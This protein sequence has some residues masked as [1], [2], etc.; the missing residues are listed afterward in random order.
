MRIEQADVAQLTDDQL[1]HLAVE[2][3]KLACRGGPLLTFAGELS[4]L[5]DC[6]IDKERMPSATVK[7]VRFFLHVIIIPGFIF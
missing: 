6:I 3:H 4:L 7:M 1:K 5:Q 2:R